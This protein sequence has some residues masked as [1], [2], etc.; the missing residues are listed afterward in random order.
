[1]LKINDGLLYRDGQQADFKRTPNRSRSS[2]RPEIIV[3][4]DT[5]HHRASGSISWLCNKKS[6]V[7]AHFVVD[8]DGKITQLAK[9]TDKTWHA[10]RSHYKG[11]RGCNNFGVGIEIVNPGKLTPTSNGGR[12]WYGAVFDTLAHGLRFAS[13]RYHGKA[14]WMPYPEAQRKAVF[15]LC[16]AL[17]K[18]YS[19]IKDVTT[20]WYI[21][22]GRKVDTNPLFPVDQCRIETFGEADETEGHDPEG[23]L[24]KGDHG[25]NVEELQRRLVKLGFHLGAVDG[26]F[27]PL[28]QAAV[29][30]FQ[31]ENNLATDGIVGPKT[32]GVLRDQILVVESHVAQSRATATVS[33]LAKT[34][35]NTIHSARAGQATAAFL[36]AP[37]IIEGLSWLSKELQVLRTIIDPLKANVGWLAEY[38]PIGVGVAALLI[39]SA[40]STIKNA[41]LTDH[42]EGKHTGR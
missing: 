5:A 2:M 32:W 23:L 37:A 13:T 42:Q 16:R 1:M 3:L 40:F 24:R 7:S 9:C 22:P 8:I 41:R 31:A 26:D 30:K 15:E 17:A 4:H 12:A 33:D 38:W 25:E 27:G 18:E 21:S 19:S 14:L 6:R 35:S 34:G 28:T 29:L 11:R 20:H 10:G 36:S 39:W